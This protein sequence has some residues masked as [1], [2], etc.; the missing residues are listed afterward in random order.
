M[1]RGFFYCRITAV[2]FFA[3][4]GKGGIVM[5]KNLK[6]SMLL[7][8]YGELL[9]EKQRLA[10][11]YYYDEDCSLF[12]IAETMSVSRQGARDFIKRG[13]QQLLEFEEKLGL[14]EKFMRINQ[15]A[16]E[17]VSIS[18]TEKLPARI[19]EL[20]SEIKNNL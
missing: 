20:I 14:A 18:E 19:N 11:V 3:F 10:L 9:T 8:F 16:D 13:E 17:I 7:D 6:I 1:T 15:L 12:E 2:K 4:T 5:S